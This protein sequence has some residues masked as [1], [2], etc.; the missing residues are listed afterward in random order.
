[1]NDNQIYRILS[2]RFGVWHSFFFPDK[3]SDVLIYY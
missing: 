3:Y 2:F 1:M